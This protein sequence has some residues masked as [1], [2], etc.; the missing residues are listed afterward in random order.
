MS[1]LRTQQR[2]HDSPLQTL[3]G[4]ELD[5]LREMAQGRSNAAI[6]QT[7]HVSESAVSKHIASIFGKLGPVDHPAVDRRVRA[8]L[9]YVTSAPGPSS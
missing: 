2:S 7:L 8:V 5:L 6:A 9:A 1:S 3:T 4:R